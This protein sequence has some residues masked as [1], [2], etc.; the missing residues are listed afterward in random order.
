MIHGVE[1][2]LV[3]KNAPIMELKDIKPKKASKSYPRTKMT[4]PKHQGRIKHKCN[5]CGKTVYHLKRHL[6]DS[7]PGDRNAKIPSVRIQDEKTGR[8][9]SS[10]TANTKHTHSTKT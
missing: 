7:C 9:I 10:Q 1:G 2:Q 4:K 3:T 5:K 6:Q 8:F